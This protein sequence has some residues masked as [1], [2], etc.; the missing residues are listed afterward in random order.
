[1]RNTTS[2]SSLGNNMSS[3]TNAASSLSRIV[4]AKGRRD[5][6]IGKAYR[7]K[8]LLLFIILRSILRSQ[9]DAVNMTGKSNQNLNQ[10]Y[11]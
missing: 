5:V 10:Y 7:K 11:I 6:G 1:M 2:D 4:Q 3:A 9:L 8:V